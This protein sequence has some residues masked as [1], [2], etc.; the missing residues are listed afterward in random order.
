[1]TNAR[2]SRLFTDLEIDVPL[3]SRAERGRIEVHAAW[4]RLP[5]LGVIQATPVLWIGPLI[6]VGHD[7]LLSDMSS[8]A[9]GYLGEHWRQSIP[10]SDVPFFEGTDGTVHPEWATGLAQAMD[11]LAE[12]GIRAGPE[13]KKAHWLA[14]LCFELSVPHDA[15]RSL[16]ERFGVG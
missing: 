4:Q 3:F 10:D 14:W 9:Y 1:M 16:A 6:D 2:T 11:Y 15:V 12:E 5:P 7:M 13:S 8:A